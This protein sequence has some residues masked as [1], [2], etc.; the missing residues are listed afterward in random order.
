[1][2][3]EPDRRVGRFRW[4]ILA[5]VFLAI[6]INYIDRQAMSLIYPHIRDQYNITDSRYGHITAAFAWSYALG[7]M[8][9]GR[10]LDKIGTRVGY[11]IA[12]AAWSVTGAL[13][14]L[15]RGHWGFVFTRALESV[16]PSIS[17]ACVR[18]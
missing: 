12:L 18:L 15:A 5:L 11:A 8:I 3:Y 9:S 14:A 13:H 16:R 17:S 1:M 10:V 6:T 7:Q 2:E 4:V